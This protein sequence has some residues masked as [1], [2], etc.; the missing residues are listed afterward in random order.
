M[1]WDD[2]TQQQCSVARAS[3]VLGDRWTLIILSDAFLGSKRFDTFQQRLNISRT[4]LTSRLK[5]LEDHEVLA[6]TKYQ[7][8][9]DRY[10]YRLT[11]KGHDLYPVISTVLNWGDSYYS[12]D[13]E[14]P[15]IRKHV[16]CGHDIKPVLACPECNEEVTARNVAARVRESKL[17]VPDVGRGPI[18]EQAK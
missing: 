9:P 18:K 13:P 11:A 17:G 16:P 6:R 7:S 8:N 1:K 3:A 4:T 2:V 15:V 5:L 10:E 12:D 14:P